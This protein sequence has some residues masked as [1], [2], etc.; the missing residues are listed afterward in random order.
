MN[1]KAD[2][3]TEI[4]G[5]AFSVNPSSGT[6]GLSLT[7]YGA[8]AITVPEINPVQSVS[9][10][11]DNEGLV[12]SVNGLESEPIDI[13]TKYDPFQNIICIIGDSFGRIISDISTIPENVTAMGY[14]LSTT[15]HYFNKQFISSSGYTALGTYKERGSLKFKYKLWANNSYEINTFPMIID[16]VFYDSDEYVGNEYRYMRVRNLFFSADSPYSSGKYPDNPPITDVIF[17]YYNNGHTYITLRE[18]I[19]LELPYTTIYTT[20]NSKIDYVGS[21]KP[22]W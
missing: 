6:L 17:E 12:I 11:V 4:T 1:G 5:G 21:T 2:A 10:I 13:N 14:T 15:P 7:R 19:Y 8:G 22:T 16:N 20:Y 9:G 3:G 18:N